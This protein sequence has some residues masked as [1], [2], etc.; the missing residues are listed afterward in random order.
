MLLYE[1]LQIKNVMR[2]DKLPDPGNTILEQYG[3]FKKNGVYVVP[4]FGVRYLRINEFGCE[5]LKH[6][7]SKMIKIVI[8]NLITNIN[9]RIRMAMNGKW[10]MIS[11][12][13][14]TTEIYENVRKVVRILM[15][16]DGLTEEEKVI[17]G[18][19]YLEGS[20][21]QCMEEKIFE[22]LKGSL[23][24]MV[25]DYKIKFENIG[26]RVVKTLVGIGNIENPKWNC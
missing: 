20:Y 11:S 6:I 4:I 1:K 14:L 9:K 19:I 22:E 3:K 13:T 10:V 25:Q 5:N 2:F 26:G 18:G 23:I 12:N 16:T 21:N 24:E 15:D 8:E 7:N 17:L